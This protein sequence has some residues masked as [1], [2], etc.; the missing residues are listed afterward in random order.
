MRFYFF[1]EGDLGRAL[2]LL[3]KKKKICL[4]CLGSRTLEGFFVWVFFLTCQF[5]CFLVPRQ[6]ETHCGCEHVLRSRLSS[7]HAVACLFYIHVCLN[8]PNGGQEVCFSPNKFCVCVIDTIWISL[9]ICGIVRR[10]CCLNQH[11]VADKLFQNHFSNLSNGG[12]AM[13]NVLTLPP[14]GRM[15]HCGRWSRKFTSSSWCAQFL[16]FCLMLLVTNTNTV[17]VWS[18]AGRFAV[19]DW[20]SGQSTR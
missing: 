16:L 1:K 20:L 18:T 7:T 14:G 4:L 2:L 15:L 8:K 12:D 11:F 3:V 17:I 6:A 5:V 19:L 10:S 13:P 9:N